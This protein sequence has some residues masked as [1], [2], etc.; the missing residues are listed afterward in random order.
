MQDDIPVLT[1][2]TVS[3]VVD[4]DDIKTPWSH[5]TSPSDGSGDGSLTEG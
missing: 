5:G 1:S 4:E 3:I 2:G